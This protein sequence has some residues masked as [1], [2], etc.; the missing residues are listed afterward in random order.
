MR[1]WIFNTC[2]VLTA[3]VTGRTT[4]QSS[5]QAQHFDEQQVRE[6][7]S[8]TDVD[9]LLI[10]AETAM[11][12]NRSDWLLWTAKSETMD[13]ERFKRTSESIVRTVARRLFAKDFIARTTEPPA[14]TPGAERG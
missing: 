2:V 13:D 14:P 12:D 6:C 10:V 1:A 8:G 9:G 4:I 11:F 3:C 5:E 7:I